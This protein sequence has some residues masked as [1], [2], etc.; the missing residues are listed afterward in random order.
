MKTLH[1]PDLLTWSHF[2][3]DRNIDF[4][5]FLW[6]RP[7]GNVAIDP[8]PLTDHDL[9]HL[10]SLGPLSAIVITNSD[11]IR[12]AEALSELTGAQIYGPSQEREDFPIDCDVWLSDGAEPFPGLRCYAM[13]GSKTPGE[14][15]FVLDG[16]TLITGDLIRSHA[17]GSLMLL[18]PDKL[19]NFEEAKASVE[20]LLSEDHIKAVLVGDGWHVFS[21]GHQRLKDLADAL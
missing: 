1:R 7:E 6:L 15:A 11:H 8:Q 2:D 20:R 13:D 19:K 17:A 3:Q 12:D 21:E 10:A 14:L 9:K 16:T 4:N 18:P 5:S